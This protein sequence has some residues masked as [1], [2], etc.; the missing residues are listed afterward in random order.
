MKFILLIVITL[1]Y[2]AF[3]T[4]RAFAQRPNF[5][6]ILIDDAHEQTIPPLGPSFLSYPSV[7]RVYQEG[8][9]FCD[10]YCTQPLC[11]PS[12]ESMYTGLYPHSTRV[13]TNTAKLP[14]GIPTFWTITADN[15]YHNQYVGK[16]NNVE[17]KNIAGLQK[18]LVVTTVKQTNP[19]MSLNGKVKTY[20]G[21][22]TV[23]IDDSATSWLS[24]IDTPFVFGIGH[25][26]THFPISVVAAYSHAYDGTATM[27]SNFFRYTENYPSYMYSSGDNYVTD[28]A[29]VLRDIEKSYEI[30]LEIDRGVGNVFSV[31]EARGLLENT[32]IIF[33][34]DNGFFYGEH[35]FTGKMDAR[36]ETSGVP[37]FI[38]YPAW[39]S[40]GS[41]VCNNFIGLNDLC[42]T[43]LDA[44]GIDTSP[45]H[46]QGRS[47][48]TLLQ[49]GNERTAIYLEGIRTVPILHDEVSDQPS[50]RAVRT[51]QF[52]YI[53]NKCDSFAEELYDLTIDP[54]ENTNQVLNPF[55]ADTVV[56]MRDLLNSLAIATH[57]TIHVDTLVQHC[58]LTSDPQRVSMYEYLEE[59]GIMDVYPNPSSGSININI[60]AGDAE[61]E[62]VTEIFDMMG[63]KLLYA[64]NSPGLIHLS[65]DIHSWQNGIYVVKTSI[66]D[67]VQT[68]SFLVQK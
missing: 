11:N 64:V 35:M 16:Y 59:L 5:V 60:P 56:Q 58:H 13:N 30:M 17:K 20:T 39:F 18:S 19:K 61:T 12:R 34:N 38:R 7:S 21:N 41:E 14:A 2:F 22:T 9:R 15:G 46:F 48:R 42:P 24:K 37:L 29:K 53:W 43:I 49:P 40:S 3:S 27:P 66:D 33:T 23:I 44:A 67:E 4:T 8:I 57:D 54:H 6:I 10:A 55:Y 51:P 31:L 68:A 62:V 36:E 50:W 52:K 45:Y 32:M 26:G 65:I 63:R 28:S 25:V 1:L 47:I